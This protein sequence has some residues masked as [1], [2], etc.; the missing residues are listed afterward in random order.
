VRVESG[1]LYYLR[2]VRELGLAESLRQGKALMLDRAATVYH[3][4]QKTVDRT[5]QELAELQRR[6]EAFPNLA[7]RLRQRDVPRFF[8]KE[9]DFYRSAL[10]QHFPDEQAKIVQAADL[11]V[12]HVFDLLGSGPKDLNKVSG[13]GRLPWNVDFKSGYAWDPATFYRD[14]RYGNVPGVDVKVPW[15]LSR[16]QHLLPMGQAYYLT[17]DEKY[18]REF[19]RQVEDWIER[20][21]YNHGV[22]WTC[23]M[24]VGIRAVNWIWA[25]HFF[26]KSTEVSDKFMQQFLLSLWSH[27]R[28]IRLN[29]E[30]RKAT[31]KGETRRLNS[32]HYLSDLIGLLYI[33]LLFPEL[34]LKK[35]VDFTR[36]ELEIEILEQTGEDGVDYEHS[37]FYHRLVTE[38]FASGFILLR[39]NNYNILP[40]TERRLEKMAEYI[41]DYLRPDGTAPQIGDADNGRLHPLAVR[42]MADHRYLPLVVGEFLGHSPLRVV[43]GDAEALWWI[44]ATP[45]KVGDPRRSSVSYRGNAF[46]I[47][48]G[49]RTHVFISAAT[50][51]MHGLGSH[52]HNDI[53]SFEYW[54]L[55]RSWI[56]DPGTFLYTP[57][58]E[59]R[60]LFRSSASHNTVRV[61]GEEINPFEPDHLFQMS[62]VAAVAIRHWKASDTVDTFEAEH[63]GYHRL[64]QG[65]VTHR[66]LFRL[67][68]KTG[69]LIIE[70]RFE[71][72]GVHTFEWFFHVAPEIHVESRGTDMELQ[73]AGGILSLTFEGADLKSSCSQGWYSPSYGRR[74][75][76]AVICSS[77]QQA[78]PFSV[79]TRLSVLKAR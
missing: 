22:N 51:G 66:R 36:K 7:T 32:N 28:F 19:V 11:A 78:P 15:E 40:A 20:N 57:D 46:T 71:G 35:E 39:L 54:A 24:D 64:K 33:A 63:N 42:E 34:G 53:L 69:E 27:A 60:N 18:P 31:V 1:I 70:D 41:T 59:S 45:G 14:I 74:Q 50:V 25:F 16:F 61:D 3:G 38:I 62:D 12:A 29:L 5:Q 23:A 73:A 79:T 44:G 56:V 8:L 67:E 58:R 10:Q 75:P 52:S 48:R 43:A 13:T 55:G 68:K 65:A 77:C 9:P 30:F 26:R 47:M 17:G 72:S 76:A 2:R 6:L 21:P 4:Y 49:D 37:T